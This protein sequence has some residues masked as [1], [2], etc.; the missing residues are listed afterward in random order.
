MQAAT[1]NNNKPTV[2]L[3]IQQDGVF[4]VA[5]QVAVHMW[6]REQG[7]KH[8]YHNKIIGNRRIVNLEFDNDDDAMLFKLTWSEYVS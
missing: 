5:D 8:L 4:N 6:L 7:I 1:S 2:E 3:N